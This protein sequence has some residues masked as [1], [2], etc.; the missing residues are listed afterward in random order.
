[1]LALRVG[2]LHDVRSM[3]TE[4]LDANTALE[5]L[6]KSIDPLNKD[7]KTIL[8]KIEN[9]TIYIPVN[10]LDESRVP[11]FRERFKVIYEKSREG[12]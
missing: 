10:N 2:T 6:F 5:T 4:N 9:C 8:V 3:R 12:I 7:S 11:E 1:V